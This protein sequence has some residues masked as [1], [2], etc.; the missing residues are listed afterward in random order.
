MESQLLYQGDR[1]PS[2]RP[3]HRSRYAIHPATRHRIA[4]SELGYCKKSLRAIARFHNCL[5]TEAAS[6]AGNVQSESSSDSSSGSELDS[7]PDAP[8]KILQKLSS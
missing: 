3:S 7:E 8:L 5:H 1:R 4:R 2:H 6:P